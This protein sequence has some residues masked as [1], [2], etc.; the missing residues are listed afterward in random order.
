MSNSEI[1]HFWRFDYSGEEVLNDML[2]RGVLL[3]PAK[4]TPAAKNDPSE[5]LRKKLRVGHGVVLAKF[6]GT[7][8]QMVAIGVVRELP[9]GEPPRVDWVRARQQLYPHPT[10][11][12]YWRTE[13]C[14]EIDGAPA[15]RY[16][17]PGMFTRNFSETA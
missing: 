17:L 16:R 1:K 3:A 9:D 8:G 7:A 11:A 14:F 10:G 12:R 6:D 2:Q 4:Y 5:V 15:N 13:A